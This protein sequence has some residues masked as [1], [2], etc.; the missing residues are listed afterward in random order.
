[1]SADD[2]G[3]HSFEFNGLHISSYSEQFIS[4]FHKDCLFEL[5]KTVTIQ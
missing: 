2:S 3:N 1:M 4:G 5:G